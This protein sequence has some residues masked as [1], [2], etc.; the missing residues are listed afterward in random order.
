MW[1]HTIIIHQLIKYLINIPFQILIHENQ[2]Q[3]KLWL[4]QFELLFS[5][6]QVKL[7]NCQME[8]NYFLLYLTK[9]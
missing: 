9:M 1:A 7:R 4:D 5:F 3:T 2:S 8:K 6:K